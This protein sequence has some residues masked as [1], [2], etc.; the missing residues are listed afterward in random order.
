M[1][2]HQTKG[3]EADAMIHEF[4]DDDYFDREGEPLEKTLRLLSLAISRAR[5]RVVA[6]LPPSPHPL[7][8]PFAQLIG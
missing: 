1:N 2:Y 3:R 4:Q 7:V 5:Q 8:Q 6:L